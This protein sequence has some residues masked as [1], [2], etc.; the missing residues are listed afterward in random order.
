MTTTPHGA[1]PDDALTLAALVPAYNE[2]G[3]LA[4]VLEVLRGVDALEQIIVVND[5]STDG[6]AADAQ[7]AAARDGRVTCLTLPANQ[8]KAQAVFAGARTTTARWLLMLDAD[9]TGLRR[10]HIDALWQ[11]VCNDQADMAVGVF[12]AGR[13][14]TDLSHWLTPWLS[15]QR[16]LSTEHLRQVARQDV[17]GYGLETALTL[18]ARR[19]RWRCR[20]VT[21]L[22][23]AHPPSESHRG[24]VLAGFWHRLGMYGQIVATAWICGVRPWLD[25]ARKWARRLTLLAVLL[26]LVASFL[27]NRSLASALIPVNALPVIDVAAAH[28]LLVI[29]PHPDDET[30]GAGGMLQAA[31]AA[32]LDVRVAV[33]TNGDG[34]R[35]AP[36]AVRGHV[37]AHNQDYVALGITRQAETLAALAELGVPHGNVIFLGYPDRGLLPLWRADWT[38]DCPLRSRYTGSSASPYQLSFNPAAQYC[39]QDVLQDLKTLL[40]E[41]HPDLVVIP[42]PEDQHPDHAATSIFARLA[43]AELEQ[44]DPAYQPQVWGYLVH[45]GDYPQPRGLRETRLL[46]PPRPLAGDD[47]WRVPLTAPQVQAKAQALRAYTT[48]ELLLGSFLPSFARPDELFARLAATQSPRLLLDTTGLVGPVAWFD[49]P[50]PARESTRRLLLDGADLVELRVGQLGDHAW[51]AAATRGPLSREF[52]YY[53]LLKTPDGRTAQLRL[54]D[55]ATR[56]G[57]TSFMAELDLAALHHPRLLSVAAE[58]RRGFTLERTAWHVV[59]LTQP[60]AGESP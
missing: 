12:R 52:Q 57:P 28:R 20:Q 16:C 21:L 10:E 36:L 43:L 46:P 26:A 13:W 23:V 6:T 56:I 9:L 14:N 54:Y 53:L 49:W 30:I 4:A 27:Y 29:A 5:G 51:L 15:G 11:P 45:Y 38:R 55:T 1:P 22:G 25:P 34:Q 40:T 32:G 48:Q 39:G 42:H 59:S 8:G 17:P 47:W 33:V 50:E 58:V 31:L 2:A 60:S 44:A 41:F 19:G 7:A 18:M 3:R 37:R 24:G 35:L